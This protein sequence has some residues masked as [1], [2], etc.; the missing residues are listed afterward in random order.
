[1]ISPRRFPPSVTP[2]ALD[3]K[4]A[5]AYCALSPNS[6]DK[7]VAAGEFPAAIRYDSVRKLVWDRVALDKAFDN[8]ADSGELSGGCDDWD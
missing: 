5:A 1:M 3:R 8:L 2:R 7:A 6:F 4:S